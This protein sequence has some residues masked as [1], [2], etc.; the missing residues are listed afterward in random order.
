MQEAPTSSWPALI[1]RLLLPALG[2]VGMTGP[3]LA[4]VYPEHR[5][6]A[7]L[8]VRYP[9]PGAPSGIRSPVGRCA[10]GTR[11]AA[12]RQGSRSGAGCEARVHRLGGTL[13]DR[14]RPFVLERADDR[15]GQRHRVDPQGRRDR[16]AAQ[17]RPV[18]DLDNT[19]GTPTRNAAARSAISAASLRT[20]LRRLSESTRCVPPTSSCR[21]PT[22]TTHAGPATTMPTSCSPARRTDFTVEEYVEATLRPGSAIN[23]I[24]VFVW[25]HLSALQKA[26]RLA[27]ESLA[28]ER[29]CRPLACHAVR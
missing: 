13:G 11:S 20:K 27:R 18:T 23:A 22:P 19:V 12:V 16:G 1:M 28:P 14:R 24:G 5:D 3:A 15:H 6:I 21:A 29:A 7:V 4:W 26:T 10:H 8:A 2:L 25:Y 17:G 9:R